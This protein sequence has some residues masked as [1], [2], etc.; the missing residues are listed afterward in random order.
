LEV[1]DDVRKA[2]LRARNLSGEHPIA[3]MDENFDQI[4]SHFVPPTAEEGY[5]SFAMVEIRMPV[6]PGTVGSL[7][8]ASCRPQKSTVFS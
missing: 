4:T 6:E 1:P 3:T 2:R 5:A 8:V 7:L